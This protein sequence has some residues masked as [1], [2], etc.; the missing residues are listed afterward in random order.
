MGLLKKV[1]TL[2]LGAEYEDEDDYLE[3]DAADLYDEPTSF[4]SER[5]R[6][7]LIALRG[8]KRFSKD[9][10]GSNIL[11]M[12][13]ALTQE[14]QNVYICKPRSIDN[15]SEVCTQFKDSA[16]CIV[17]LEGLDH[18]EAQ[19]IADFLCGAVFVLDGVIECITKE[20]F[21]MA[22]SGFNVSTELREQIKSGS[23]FLSW[24][25]PSARG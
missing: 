14:Q 21:V 13:T 16:V 15:A 2:M 17:S 19:R 10:A 25:L 9:N 6:A 1:Q 18:E 22:P 8:G 3:E 20:V 4:R 11:T 24:V 7:D 23:S 12:P 5:D